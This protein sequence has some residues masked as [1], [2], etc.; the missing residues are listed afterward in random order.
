MHRVLLTAG[1]A[2]TR[3]AYARIIED[4]A[5]LTVQAQIPDLTHALAQLPSLR[6][7]ILLIDAVALAPSPRTTTLL[8]LR[9]AAAHSRLAVIGDTPAE[10]ISSLL[11]A[12]VTGILNPR[13]EAG[14]FVAALALISQGG[15][16]VSSPSTTTRIFASP[17]S[18]VLDQLST[19]ER[20]I[21]ALIAT[22][23]DNK[24][25]AQLLGISPL[26]VK[27][28]VNRILGKLGASSRAHLVTIA[29]ESGLVSPG[30]PAEE[31]SASESPRPVQLELRFRSVGSAEQLLVFG[32]AVEVVEPTELRD[33]LVHRAQ[34]TTALYAGAQ[35][36]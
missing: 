8:S 24:T 7:D 4:S 32:P 29:Y 6:P 11:R 33:A 18:P 14:P 36:G 28:H 22:Q 25:V 21:L 19:R 17:A 10:E 16:V 15:T 23:P 9:R 34:E 12:G 35:T 30:P 1:P 3:D 31:A 2:L 20:Q 13:I 27:S 5:L 26:T